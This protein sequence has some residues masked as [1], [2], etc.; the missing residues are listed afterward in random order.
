MVALEERERFQGMALVEDPAVGRTQ[1]GG[2]RVDASHEPTQHGD[3]VYVLNSADEGSIT[4][5]R[6]GEEGAL[7]PIAGSTRGTGAARWC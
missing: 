5:F 3:L 1:I 6:L 2:D 4:G 7:T